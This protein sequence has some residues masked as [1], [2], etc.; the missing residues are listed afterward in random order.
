L[1]RASSVG[2][3]DLIPMNGPSKFT[4]ITQSG[5][6]RC[7][8]FDLRGIDMVARLFQ[9]TQFSPSSKTRRVFTPHRAP[10]LFSPSSVT[11]ATLAKSYRHSSVVLSITVTILP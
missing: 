10:I 1:A 2:I 11:D 8:T 4:A 6:Q 5:V 9:A 7:R 3:A